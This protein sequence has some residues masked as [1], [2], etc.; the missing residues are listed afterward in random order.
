MGF[1][2]ELAWRLLPALLKGAG[3]TLGVLMPCL[4]LGMII[5]IPISLWR[6][7]KNR[8]TGGVAWFFAM[9]FRGVPALILLYMIY[10]GLA[11]VGFVRNTALWGIFVDP[12]YCAVIGFTLNHAGF[13]VELLRG[14][15]QAVPTGL[16]DA[17]RSLGLSR[18]K[19]FLL[20]TLPLGIRYGLSAYMNE[21]ILFVKG[22]AALGAITLLDLLAV[23]NS[24]VSTTYDPMT[25]LIMAAAIYWSIVQV[26]RTMFMYLERYLNRHLDRV[27]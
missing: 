9:F 24:A 7:S 17:A 10:N 12:Y 2:I 5:S 26:V 1:D 19:I 23:A 14:A 16:T 20:V 21:V 15:F 27:A 8:A 4:V 18:R 3:V 22:T 6:L 11:T 13:L 25:P